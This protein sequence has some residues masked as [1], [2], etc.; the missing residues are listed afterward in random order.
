MTISSS[1]QTWGILIISSV[2]VLVNSNVLSTT[3]NRHPDAFVHSHAIARQSS[4]TFTKQNTH[5]ISS[6]NLTE[7]V[8]E[9]PTLS[10]VTE[11]IY[12][13]KAGT[14]G[15]ILV[16]EGEEVNIMKKGPPSDSSTSTELDT[17]VPNPGLV[18]STGGTLGRQFGSKLSNL[19]PLDRIALTANGNLQRIIS[20]YYDA[21]VHVH[22]DRCDR[23]RHE[24]KHH[25]DAVWDRTIHLS[26]L[27]QVRFDYSF[28]LLS[29]FLISFPIFG[30]IIPCKNFCVATSVIS[31]YSEECVR[32][33]ESG[34]IGIGQLFRHL[35]KLPT[36]HLMDAGRNANGGLWRR[37][38][39]RSSELKCI[40]QEDFS[41]NVWELV[42]QQD[43]ERFGDFDNT[44]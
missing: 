20:S 15:D 40:I 1:I 42:P 25:C 29:T 37:Y 27:G 28:F 3:R 6:T 14:L 33:V 5:F 18:T 2:G 26:V 43:I 35:D 44:F 8:L 4:R 21:P 41:P 38:E 9:E 23:R 13:R 12:D 30:T 31:V 32:I 39:L 22:I 7:T 16:S 36:F 10:R 24:C 34:E 17:D 11:T 19:T